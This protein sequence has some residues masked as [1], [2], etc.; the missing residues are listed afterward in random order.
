MLIDELIVARLK[1]GTSEL[2][3]CTTNYERKQIYKREAVRL[4]LM[5][6]LR[7]S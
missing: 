7:D 6:A 3:D 5:E 2:K 4:A 1:S